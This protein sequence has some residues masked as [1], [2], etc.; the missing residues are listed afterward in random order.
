MVMV[1]DD[2]S[3]NSKNESKDDE[4][5]HGLLGG[6]VDGWMD[7]SMGSYWFDDEMRARRGGAWGWE[8]LMIY[9]RKKNKH[10]NYYTHEQTKKPR[11]KQDWQNGGEY[12]GAPNPTRHI[13]SEPK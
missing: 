1:V 12:F 10:G 5:S 2:I 8:G 13:H 4:R 9:N 11:H 6:L 7:G 3:T